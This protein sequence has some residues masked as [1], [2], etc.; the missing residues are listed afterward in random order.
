MRNPDGSRTCTYLSVLLLPGLHGTSELFAPFIAATPQGVST[1]ALEY[2]SN[3]TS[4]DILEHFARE[5][6]VNPCI[7][8]AESFSGPIG[9][10]IA[11]DHRVKALILC[12][13]FVSSPF[14]RSLGYLSVAPLFWIPLPT[15][16]IRV[17]L[18]G[19]HADSN[20]VASVQSVLRRV[21]ARTIARRVRQ[22]S[23]DR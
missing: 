17:L 15:F 5:N 20:L 6:L 9:V 7:V 3:E 8:I 19:R 18:S 11:T 13:S 4:I 1:I 10:R 22:L 14:G 16:L 2:P 23:Q 12:N 21:P